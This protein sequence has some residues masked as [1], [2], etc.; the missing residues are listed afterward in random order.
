MVNRTMTRTST[1]RRRFGFYF[2]FLLRSCL[3]LEWEKH[4]EWVFD[5]TQFEKWVC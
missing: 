1:M 5:W 4:L 2:Q 3:Q